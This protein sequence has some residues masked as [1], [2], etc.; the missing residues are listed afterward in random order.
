MTLVTEV[1]MI[2]EALADPGR[3]V[4]LHSAQIITRKSSKTL[5]TPQLRTSPSPIP[6]TVNIFLF[7]TKRLINPKYQKSVCTMCVLAKLPAGTILVYLQLLEGVASASLLP[8]PGPTE[9]LLLQ[10]CAKLSDPSGTCLLYPE[11]SPLPCSE[12]PRS[13]PSPMSGWHSCPAPGLLLQ[14]FPQCSLCPVQP[15]STTVPAQPLFSQFLG[16][17]VCFFID[18][19][20][21]NL[22]P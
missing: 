20:Q 22:S 9:L 14:T 12:S 4:T 18:P 3:N 21:G 15:G 19:G 17:W 16:P 1:L 13:S 8:T 7:F 5:L 2:S 11:V 10:L 6:R